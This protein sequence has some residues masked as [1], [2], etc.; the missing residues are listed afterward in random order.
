MFLKTHKTAS[1]AVQNILLRYADKNKLTVGLS[2]T[3]DI[4]FHYGKKFQEGYVA[5]SKTPINI[6]CHHMVFNE[7]EVRKVMPA[8]SIYVTILREPTALFE[9]MFDYFHYDSTPFSRVKRDQLE[10]WLD[11][12]DM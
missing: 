1:T 11:H 9:S 8:N 4:R 2:Q 12:T 7:P 6:L 3:Y 10:F 5:K